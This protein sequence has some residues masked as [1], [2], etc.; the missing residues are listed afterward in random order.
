MK[1]DKIN[2]VL[3]D[4]LTRITDSAKGYTE[5]G[6]SVRYAQLRTLFFSYAEQRETF[7]AELQDLIAAHGGEREDEPS[8]SFLGALHRA[9]MDI[10]ADL[11][12]NKAEE[13]LEETVRGEER[14]LEDYDRILEE[15]KLPADLHSVI[16]KQR[17]AVD[18]A[19]K[20]MLKLEARYDVI[21]D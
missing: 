19:L 15:Y 1:N 20:K 7:Q 3:E 12:E 21:E 5:A 13:V 4:L 9:W 16:L 18:A 10:K 17:N 14:T 2:D 8:G 11:D 6:N